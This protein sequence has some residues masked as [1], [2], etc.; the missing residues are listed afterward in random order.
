M[1]TYQRFFA[2]FLI[3]ILPFFIISCFDVPKMASNPLLTEEQEDSTSDTNSSS[4]SLSDE[5]IASYKTNLESENF[6]ESVVTSIT[7]NA[8][9][10]ITSQ[11]LSS[12]NDISQIG[13][14]LIVSLESTTFSGNSPSS[15]GFESNAASFSVQSLTPSYKIRAIELALQ[16]LMKKLPDNIENVNASSSSSTSGEASSNSASNSPS[17]APTNKASSSEYSSPNGLTLSELN[18]KYEFVLKAFTDVSIYNLSNAGITS[19]YINLAVQGIMQTISSNMQESGITASE[20]PEILKETMQTAMVAISTI[21][22]D[23]AE[24]PN[25]SKKAIEGAIAGTRNL[26]LGDTFVLS[27]IDE[28]IEGASIGLEDTGYNTSFVE[29][30]VTSLK[31]GVDQGIGTLTELSSTEVESFETDLQQKASSTGSKMS[32]FNKNKIKG[33]TIEL[34]RTTI[35]KGAYANV[36][37]IASYFASSRKTDVIEDTVFYTTNNLSYADKKLISLTPQ[38]SASNITAIYGDF[39]TTMNVITSDAEIV[40]I[41]ISPEIDSVPRGVEVDFDAIATMTDGT[42]A[43][44]SDLCS[45]TSS[46]TASTSLSSAGIFSSTNNGEITVTA[47]RGSFTDSITFSLSSAVLVSM[48]IS[49][50]NASIPLGKS[51]KFTVTGTHSD[52]SNVTLSPNTLNWTNADEVGIAYAS[53]LGDFTIIAEK[54]GIS[55]QTT[56]TYTEKELENILLVYTTDKIAKGEEILFSAVGVYTDGTTVSKTNEVTWNSSYS[57]LAIISDYRTPGTNGLVK[58]IQTSLEIEAANPLSTYI[59]ASC[60][61]SCDDKLYQGQTIESGMQLYV[62]K[63]KLMS[64]DISPTDDT[65]TMPSGTNRDTTVTGNYSDGSTANLNESSECAWT[66]TQES[67]VVANHEGRLFALT[68]GTSTVAFNCVTIHNTYT[69]SYAVTVVDPKLTSITLS[70]SNVDLVAP[71]TYYVT[72]TGYYTDNSV[73][74]ITSQ[75]EWTTTNSNL[76]VSNGLITANNWGVANITAKLDDVVSSQV[77]VKARTIKFTRQ[78]NP[79]YEHVDSELR[80]YQLVEDYYTDHSGAIVVTSSAYRSGAY[81]NHRKRACNYMDNGVQQYIAIVYYY[82]EA[83]G[84]NH[85]ASTACNLYGGVHSHWI[86]WPGPSNYYTYGTCGG[87]SCTTGPGSNPNHAYYLRWQ[88]PTG[89]QRLD[90]QLC[91]CD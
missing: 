59:T 7:T 75:A 11:G 61:S 54:G 52:G 40:S 62:T 33:I 72:A 38:E 45:W 70:A 71:N 19:D 35:P 79:G 87:H 13:R 65:L 32:F 69:K 43:D 4:S 91:Y 1:K 85:H 88:S 46:K 89:A 37:V 17:S 84:S 36:K 3:L 27:T 74:D 58:T 34:D 25:V 78:A 16:T 64:V 2:G 76:S 53:D 66:S 50:K 90:F 23:A 12:S 57:S 44:I 73:K 81:Q 24:V 63:E 68:P 20:I 49:P 47:E 26:L 77:Y 29:L 30:V 83:Y 8:S 56:I 41:A 55:T 67:F 22:L 18:L 14:E 42:T 82:S 80:T 31:E 28:M 86:D 51:Q 48:D 6:S 39:T 9:N 15:T 5:V 21:G 10:H 60:N